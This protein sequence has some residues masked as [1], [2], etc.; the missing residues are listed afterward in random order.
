MQQQQNQEEEDFCRVCRNG[1]TPDNPLSY[2]CKCSGSIKYIHQ[3]CLLEW[4]QHSKSSSC[5]LCGHPFRFT[6]I[7]SPN[8]PEFIP[9]HELFYE[10]L[11]RFKWYIKKISRILYIVFCW[12]FIVPTVTCWIFNFFF[13]QK[14]LV[15]LGRVVM[16]NSGFGSSHH[17]AVTLFYDFFIGTT[18]FFWIILASIASYMIID[19]IHHKHAE[20]EIQDE[21]EFDSDDTYLQNLQQPQQ[22]LQQQ[23][24]PQLQ[25]QNIIQ[26]TDDN[27]NNNNTT[28]EENVY[29]NQDLG[30]QI[31]D[32][33]PIR[34]RQR[35]RQHQQQQQ[36]HLDQIRLQELQEQLAETIS[37]DDQVGQAMIQDQITT[38]QQQIQR[39]QQQQQQQQQQQ[40][41][42]PQQQQQQ[43]QPVAAG[44]EPI[45][46]QPQQNQRVF[47]RIPG[48]LEMLR[49]QDVPEE[50]ENDI[51]N[52]P[53]QID[54]LEHFIGLSGPL[55]NI[56]THCFILIVYNA[57]FL[58]TF[59]YFPYLIGHTFIE[60]LPFHVKDIL[61][62]VDGSIS[63]CVAGVAVGYT[64]LSFTAL[65]ILSILIKEKI[66]FKISTLTHSFIKI[67]VITIFEL[68]ILPIVVG[69]FIDFC[70]LRIFGGSIEARL[71]FA[72]S[73]KMTFLFSRWIFGIFFMVNFTNLCSIFH[74]IFRKGVIWFLKD[75]S[76]PDFDPFKDMIRHL[77][78]VFVSLCAYSIIGLLFVFLPALFLSTI[79]GFLPI[80]LQVNDPI[81]KGSADILFIVAASFFPKF[82]TKITIKNIVKFWITKSSKILSLES[83]LLPKEQQQNVQT[84]NQQQQQQEQEEEEEVYNEE[85]IEEDDDEKEPNQQQQQ[86]QQQQQKQGQVPKQQDVIFKPNNFKKRISL[87]IFL[88]WLTLFLAI[89]AYISIPV[90]VGRLILGPF[91]NDND[92]YCILVG[93]FCGWILSKIAFLLFSPS[94][95]I[96]IIQWVSIGLKV[97]LIGFI[98]V[99]VIPLLTGFLFDFIFMVPIMAPY[100]ES[101]FIHFGDIFQ[102]WCLGALLLKF[103]YRWINAT[104]QNPD[105]NR[106]NVIEDLD[107]PRDRW[108][109]RFKQFK[110]NGISNIDLKWTFSKIIFPICHY[111]FT[112]LT[113]PIFFS[114][115]L[116]PLFGGSLILESISFR[117]GFAVYCFILLFEKILHKVKQWSSRFHNMIRDD[118]YLVGKQLH[119]I[120]QQQPL[121]LDDSGNGSNQT[122]S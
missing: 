7:Y 64:I 39:N 91:S 2:P 54:D 121:K 93:L 55:F 42:Q 16:E 62:L 76:D 68:G 37:R 118:K 23:P 95:S 87:F 32:D 13:G 98:M 47:F 114:K 101:F 53:N 103:W 60:K 58:S 115:F 28:N 77:F 49:L 83:Y 70:S 100:D 21:F 52:D 66:A 33:M 57:I 111:L 109:D 38:L 25:Q 18:L 88:G 43:Q 63:Q 117:Y 27:N 14:W 44:G 56:L 67:G 79:P 1:S 29:N 51:E 71:S 113:V 84:A 9:S 90:L 46:L 94:S 122:I 36:K 30:F 12:L 26:Q 65:I 41:Q 22:P 112:L 105:N 80:N 19:F 96:N 34:L 45:Q 61:K 17:T 40:P 110:R 15:P 72:L 116:V 89:C 97:L 107:Q 75:P 5:E 6:P 31:T 78:K 11:I 24:P 119:N 120:D 74:Q 35:L 59:L 108:I 99:I 4:I 106:N 10:A 69:C 82:D 92:I 81:T 104:N 20:I 50:H 86:Q 8:A 48:V 73:Q 85:E 3:N 102:N